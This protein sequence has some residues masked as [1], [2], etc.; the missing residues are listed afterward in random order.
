MFE[1]EELYGLTL[2]GTFKDEN[3]WINF[4]NSSSPEDVFSVL[5][6]GA[7][8]SV[9]ELKSTVNFKKKSDEESSPLETTEVSASGF[10]DTQFSS[11]SQVN[12]LDKSIENRGV[13]FADESKNSIENKRAFYEDK[14]ID[15]DKFLAFKETEAKR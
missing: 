15:F 5:S 2:E 1:I 11:D 9:D 13:S 4:V 6:E 12:D 8:S 7:F 3:E 14:G 10:S